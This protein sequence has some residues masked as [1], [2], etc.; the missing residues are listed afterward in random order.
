[1]LVGKKIKEIRKDDVFLHL[2]VYFRRE[3]KRNDQ[4]LDSSTMQHIFSLTWKEMK[5]RERAK[6]NFTMSMMNQKSKYIDE[7]VQIYYVTKV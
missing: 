3:R 7:K 1:M 5:R 6:K 4:T 2:R